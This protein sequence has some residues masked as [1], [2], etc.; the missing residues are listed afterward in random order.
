MKTKL[1]KSHKS[2]RSMEPY[3]ITIIYHH[4]NTLKK[5]KILKNIINQLLQRTGFALAT[6]SHI[7]NK[8][9]LA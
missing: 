4:K 6:R 3:T 5:L 9:P 2:A 7:Y 1:S 8:K